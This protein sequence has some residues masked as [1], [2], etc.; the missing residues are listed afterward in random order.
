MVVR[1][2]DRLH[3]LRTRV[4]LALGGRHD[5]GGVED[6]L[7]PEDEPTDYAAMVTSRRGTPPVGPP[8]RPRWR[9]P[10]ADVA[11]AA[12]VTALSLVSFLERASLVVIT[13]DGDDLHYTDPDPFGAVEVLVG[14][15]ALAWRRIAPGTVLL[16]CVTSQFIRYRQRYPVAALPFAVVVAIYTVAQLWPL[17]R[18]A[19]CLLLVCVVMA[20]GALVFLNPGEY[21]EGLTEVI[22]LVCAW[23]LGRGVRLERGRTQLLEQH[24]RLLEDRTE[25]FAHEQEALA[26]LSAARERASIARELHDIVS[27]NVGVIVLRASTA[28]R[29]AGDAPASVRDALASIEG[30]GKSALADMRRLVGVLHTD[31]GD[32]LPMRPPHLGQ[33]EILVASIVEAGTSVELEITGDRRLLPPAIELNAFRIVQEGLSN[34]LKHATGSAVVVRVDFGADALRIAVRDFGGG[35]SQAES[36]GRGLLGMRQRVSSVGGCI[37]VGPGR[38]GG[39]LVDALLPLDCEAVT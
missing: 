4:P 21:D 18:S 27:G 37:Y 15:S 13:D 36:S 26:A 19:W 14:T 28:R 34:A 12:L 31:D 17:A 25:R 22:T 30:L 11:L 10:M 1:L 32:A 20:F 24:A 16:I 29:G 7:L 5:G 2:G 6:G 33:L 39:F 8:G 3:L 38:G 35:R 9:P 23:S